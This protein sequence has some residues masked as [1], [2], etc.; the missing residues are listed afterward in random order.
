MI[1]TYANKLGVEFFDHQLDCFND[2]ADRMCLYYATGKGKS[3]TALVSMALMG[4][5]EALVITPPSTYPEWI[6]L[7]KRIGVEV[8]TMSHA[9]FR[10]KDTKLSRNKAIVADEMHMFGGHGG[11]GWGKLDTLSRHL[12]APLIMASATPNY[13]D[14]DRVYCIQHILDPLSCKGGFLEFLY[15][16]CI[17]EQN[18][19]GMIPNVLGFK[20]HGS[21]AEYLAALPGV[22][23]LPDELVYAIVDHPVGEWHDPVF[24][25][26]GYDLRTHRMVASGIEEKHKR[27]FNSLVGID[28]SLYQSVFDVVDTLCAAA[29]TP[30]LI[31]ANHSTVAEAL[32]K[33]LAA[34]GVKSATVTGS[35]PAKKKAERIA[36]FKDGVLDV[37]VGT[38]TLATGTDGLDKVCDHLIILDDTEDASLRRQLIGRI[39]PRGADGDATKKQVHRLILS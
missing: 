9:K 2:L 18:H 38:A 33:N 36:A 23:Y 15:R 19:F 5:T 32:D 16:E 4:Q 12:Q 21:A 39:M 3:I 1:E 31:Y 37:L 27:I 14:A 22:H 11:K 13:N 6:A 34:H 10:R 28:G 20:N 8:E 30:V 25:D 17:T 7:G 29:A 35:T 24:D 26:Y